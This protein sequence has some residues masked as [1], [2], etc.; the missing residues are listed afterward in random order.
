M[1]HELFDRQPPMR[2][3][4]AILPEAVSGLVDDLGAFGW[5][6]SERDRAVMLELRHANGGITALSYSWLESAEFNPSEGITL[7]FSGKT[8]KLIGRNLNIE[9]RPGVRLFEGLTRHRVLWIREADEDASAGALET[10]VVVDRLNV[11]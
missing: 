9:C 10:E 7:S 1:L 8:V 6:R 3:P 4:A 5:L 11:T 2:K